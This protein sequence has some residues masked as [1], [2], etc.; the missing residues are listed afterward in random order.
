LPEVIHHVECTIWVLVHALQDVLLN[1]LK[2]DQMQMH[3]MCIAD[4]VDNV[5]ILEC[6]DLRVI[7]PSLLEHIM[8][9]KHESFVIRKAEHRT[10]TLN[11][12]L[13]IRNE[14]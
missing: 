7:N 3:R 10:M 14:R 1:H 8:S 11:C 12:D 6:S 4:E 13:T 9:P 2:I 5:E